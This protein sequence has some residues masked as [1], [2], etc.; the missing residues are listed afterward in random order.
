[1]KENDSVVMAT[2]KREIIIFAFMVVMIYFFYL[3]KG[4]PVPAPLP[5]SVYT[6]LTGSSV[7]EVMAKPEITVSKRM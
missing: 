1:M 4:S 6:G 7:H 3:F 2:A 5:L